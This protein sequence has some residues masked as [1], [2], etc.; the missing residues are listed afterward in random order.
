[1]FEETLVCD[2]CSS[3]VDGG[4]RATTLRTLRENGGQAFDKIIGGRWHPRSSSEPWG[5]AK[6]HLCGRCVAEGRTAFY[7]GEPIPERVS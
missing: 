7:D 3:V 5:T 1:M 6:R 2:G 4:S